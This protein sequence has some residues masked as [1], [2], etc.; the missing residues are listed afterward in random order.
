MRPRIA[1]RFSALCAALDIPQPPNGTA[2]TVAEAEEIAERIGYPV[3]VRP[4]FVLGGRAM[5]VVYGRDQLAAY[6]P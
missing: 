6:N 2:A 1:N 3:L 4:S 5:R